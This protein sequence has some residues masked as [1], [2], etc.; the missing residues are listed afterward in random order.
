MCVVEKGECQIK[1]D[2]MGFAI[3]QVLYLQRHIL[4]IDHSI[5]RWD[6]INVSELLQHVS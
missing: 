3:L 1:D 6:G 5:L 2:V 4:K